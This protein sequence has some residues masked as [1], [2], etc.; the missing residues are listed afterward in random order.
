MKDMATAVGIG[1]ALGVILLANILEGGSP[2]SLFLLPP[3]LLVFG[4]TI[5]VCVAGGTLADTTHAIT[6]VKTALVGKVAT[7]AEVVP[8]TT[9]TRVPDCTSFRRML[10]LMPKS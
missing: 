8:G 1:G 3:L 10:R 7:S 5:L 6:S 9:V 4:G 2:A